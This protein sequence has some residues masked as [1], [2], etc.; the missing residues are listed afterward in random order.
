MNMDFHGLP[1]V[2]FILKTNENFFSNKTVI[3]DTTKT[4]SVI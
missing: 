2:I 1:G 4:R 3:T